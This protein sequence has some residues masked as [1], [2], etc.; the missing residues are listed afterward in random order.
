MNKDNINFV[1]DINSLN[2][3]GEELNRQKVEKFVSK[4]TPEQQKKLNSI[5]SDKQATE[6][7][8]SSP[9]A[10]AIMKSLSGK[11]KKN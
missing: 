11:K 9:Q 4:L 5:L 7:L 3:N 2:L 10:Q 6:K 1:N 8:L